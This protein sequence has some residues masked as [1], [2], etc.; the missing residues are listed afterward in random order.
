MAE[1]Y[2][3]CGAIRLRVNGSGL[4]RGTLIGLDN[5]L[6][7][8]LPTITM[9]TSPGVEPRVLTNFKNQRIRY[10]I[11]T[12]TINDYFEI[13]RYVVFTKPLYVEGPG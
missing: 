12:N 7:K 8:D 1:N 3:H 13:N 6:T 5:V 4:L 2:I 11:Y 9:A 10:K